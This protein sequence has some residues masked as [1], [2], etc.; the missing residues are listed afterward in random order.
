[1][2]APL[3]GF[4]T[5]TPALEPAKRFTEPVSTAETLERGAQLVRG[6]Q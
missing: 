4:Q 2:Y 3:P 1:M 5:F 6:Y